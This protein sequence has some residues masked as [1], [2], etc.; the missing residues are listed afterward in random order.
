MS[1]QEPDFT[2]RPHTLPSLYEK[3]LLILCDHCGYWEVVR[4][5]REMGGWR[6]KREL[7]FTCDIC[8]QGTVSAVD[9]DCGLQRMKDE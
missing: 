1:E 6:S 7:P 9:D 4:D 3:A 8:D 5:V 2:K